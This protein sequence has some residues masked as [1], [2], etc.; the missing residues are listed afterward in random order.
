MM[1]ISP[2]PTMVE[3]SMDLMEKED[4]DIVIF[5]AQESFGGTRG[6]GV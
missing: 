3:D 6:E 5:Y 2:I 4:A 1:T